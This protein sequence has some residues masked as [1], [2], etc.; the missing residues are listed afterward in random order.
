MSD[1]L[2]SLV[3]NLIVVNIKLWFAQDR[4]HRAVAESKG[5][6]AGDAKALMDL[7]FQRNRLMTAIDRILDQAARNGRADIDERPKF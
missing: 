6:P 5:L 1:T 4:L 7:N 2:G 3:D